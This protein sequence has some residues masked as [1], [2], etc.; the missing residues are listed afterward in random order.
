MLEGK[1]VAILATDGY[2]QSELTAPRDALREAGAEAMIVSLEKGSIRGV[3]GHEWA[4]EVE[5]D[6]TIDTI[7]ANAYDALVLPG[8]LYNPDKLRTN[9]AAVR[10]VRNMFDF[11]LSTLELP[12]HCF[13]DN[14]GTRLGVRNP[15]A[16]Q[17]T[18]HY[19]LYLHYSRKLFLDKIIEVNWVG[20][21]DM[22][23]DIMT[24]PLD[25]TTFLKLRNLLVE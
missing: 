18:K 9:E 21:N 7:S 10:F 6:V 20:T 3:K 13:T 25:K 23:A 4:D 5:V 2:E 16:T 24:K 12:I 22:I 14:E 11:M 15:G 1:R 17:R 8:G 19:E